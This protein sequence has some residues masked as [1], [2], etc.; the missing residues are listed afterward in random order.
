MYRNLRW[1]CLVARLAPN[2]DAR[3]FPVLLSVAIATTPLVLAL[4]SQINC[5]TPILSVV[6]EL[7]PSRSASHTLPCAWLQAR[8]E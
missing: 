1:I 5:S 3:E 6:P 8:T 7:N 4:K 2:R